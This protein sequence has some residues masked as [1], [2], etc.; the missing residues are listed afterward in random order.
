MDCVELARSRGFENI[1]VCGS[2]GP[3][4]ADLER[5]GVRTY[6]LR[7]TGKWSFALSVLPMVRLFRSN[8]ADAV[9]LYGQFAGFY[10]AVASRLTCVPAVYEADFPSFVTDAGVVSRIRNFVAEWV[11]CRLSRQTTVVSEADRREYVRGG[12]QKPT[13]LHLVP[14]GVRTP[15]ADP[16]RVQSLRHRLLDG[17]QYLLLAAGRMENQK[18]FDVLLHAMPAIVRRCPG[19]RLALVGDGPCKGSLAAIVTQEGLSDV[20]KFHPF[21]A[22]LDAWILASDV[23]VI[24]SRYEPSGLIAREAMAGGRVVVASDV[25]GLSEAIEHDRTGVLAPPNDPASLSEALLELLGNDGVG[26]RLAN[27]A[28]VTAVEKFSREA[29]W[30]RYE[31]VLTGLCQK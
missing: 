12:L 22:T 2:D 3:L 16:A 8:S 17:G 4:A 13:R 7:H 14:N 5:Q 18:G 19:V 6:V 29:M 28:R 9:L 24:P 15:T 10:G 27:A 31:S 25:Q 23:V 20:V 1:V 26:K 21:Q 11:T 30:A